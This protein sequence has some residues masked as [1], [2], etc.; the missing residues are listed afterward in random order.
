MIRLSPAKRTLEVRDYRHDWTPFLDLDT[1]V[2]QVN[3]VSGGIVL[4]SAIIEAGA[5]TVKFWISGGTP[6]Q[7]GQIIHRITTAGGRTEEEV[8][9]IAVTAADEPVSLEEAKQNM[10][11]EDDNSE[12]LLISSFIR[13]ARAFVES[14]SGYVFVQRQFVET[15]DAWPDGFIRLDR[16][17]FVSLDEFEY[18]DSAFQVQPYLDAF[19]VPNR[20]PVQ[21]YPTPG[22][23]SFPVLPTGG[24]G[25]VRYTAGFPEGSQDERVELA[26]QAILLLVGHWYANREAGTERVTEEIPFGVNSLINRFRAQVL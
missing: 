6:G 13:S 5:K 12:D 21:V 3:T 18:Y 14:E 11:I 2:S 20:A 25:T 1:I 19:V 23:T 7:P 15:F 9:T 17:P 4:D 8:F 16:R 24:V 10:K 26:R 22:T